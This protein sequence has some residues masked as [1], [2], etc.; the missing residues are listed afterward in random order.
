MSIEKQTGTVTVIDERNQFATTQVSIKE[1]IAATVDAVTRQNKKY[2][3]EVA[4][5]IPEFSGSAHEDI[6][7][8]IKRADTV[9]QLYD[10]CEE[11]TTLIIVN[12]LKG[13][14]KLWYDSKP[15]Y[16]ALDFVTMKEE[17]S[18]MFRSRE[19]K[20]TNMRRFE[21]RKWSKSEKFGVYFQ[22]KVTLGNKLN[23]SEEDLIIYLNEGFNNYGLQTQ[24]R[25]KE[26]KTLAH[27]L[28]VMGDMTQHEQ[29]IY[30]NLN[31]LGSF[32]MEDS[33]ESGNDA[34]HRITVLLIELYKI[35]RK[36]FKY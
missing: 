28:E 13:R 2:P 26:F 36:K 32:L 23:L 24:A 4:A 27:M 5:T 7:M 34:T 16:A 21:A 11:T 10:F 1:I 35:F 3:T 30:F 18:K 15:E 12:K 17:L 9:K 25:M 33:S 6:N 31:F 14:A 8:W 29:S 19:D 20:L 22:D